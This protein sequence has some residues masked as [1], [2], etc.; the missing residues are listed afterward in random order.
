M[1]HYPYP[2]DLRGFAAGRRVVPRRTPPAARRDCEGLRSAIVRE[3]RYAQST[4]GRSS[5]HLTAPSL[6]ISIETQSSTEG[7]LR[8]T[9]TCRRYWR[10]V[11]VRF[12]N[13]SRLGVGPRARMNSP[14]EIRC[15][16]RIYTKRSQERNTKI[17]RLSDDVVGGPQKK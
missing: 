13:R 11:P 1:P 12:T 15:I 10:L 6:A 8:P 14:R 2:L 3:L 9:L 5:S 4:L 17:Y 7:D 16:E